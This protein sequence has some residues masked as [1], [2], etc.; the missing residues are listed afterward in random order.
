MSPDYL[1]KSICVAAIITLMGYVILKLSRKN[2]DFTREIGWDLAFI[3]A[4]FLVVIG[5]FQVA[6]LNGSLEKLGTGTASMANGSNFYGRAKIRTVT[7]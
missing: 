2:P 4:I 1:F 6:E 7:D 5:A 3:C